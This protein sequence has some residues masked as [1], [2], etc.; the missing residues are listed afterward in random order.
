ME[1]AIHF[2]WLVLDWMSWAPAKHFI[3]VP[4]LTLPSTALLWWS[5]W[6]KKKKKKKLTFLEIKLV[7]RGQLCLYYNP[8]GVSSWKWSNESLS[9]ELTLLGPPIYLHVTIGQ[10]LAGKKYITKQ[11]STRRRIVISNVVHV[12]CEMM[13]WSWKIPVFKKIRKSP[14]SIT[15][16]EHTWGGSV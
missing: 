10:L 15:S 2:L 9:P 5:A 12:W 1:E 8:T 3:V 6:K 16:R 14:L 11:E 7:W 4:K 13:S